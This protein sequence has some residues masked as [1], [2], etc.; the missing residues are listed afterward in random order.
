M[1]Q[2]A[3]IAIEAH[4]G[5]RCQGVVAGATPHLAAAALKTRGLAPLSL[6]ADLSRPKTAGDSNAE[7]GSAARPGTDPS[8][9][10]PRHIRRFG[11]IISRQ[12]LTLF[13][14]QL[15]TLLKAGLPLLRALEVLARPERNPAFKEVLGV[16]ADGVRGGGN[17]S[18]GL[19]QF[20][21]IFDDLHVTMVTAGEAGGSLDVVLERLARFLERT[22][23]IKGRL[24]A[25][26]TY[27]VIIMLVAGLILTGLMIFVVP[28]FQQIFNGVL[29]GQPLPAL[30]RLVIAAGEFVHHHVA[31]AAGL[32]ALLYAAWRFARRSR[33]GTRFI[34]WL[35]LKPPVLG[36]LMLKAAIARFARTFGSLLASGVPILDALLIT[37]AA[38]GNVHVASAL[39]LVH[40]RVK[41]GVAVTQ[42]L[43]CAAIFPSLVTSMIQVGEETGALPEMLGRIADTYDE[44]VDNAVAAL[45]TI[46][47]PV[48]IVLMALVV[49]L[50]VIALFLPIVGIVQHL[51]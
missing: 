3:F 35:L 16:L 8:H 31:A 25:A 45:T 47:E 48:M 37:R 20:P 49:G 6:V 28:R 19:Q 41:E 1:P 30:T 2:F 15:A 39:L 23:R 11:R 29:K 14:R 46:I 40:D 7:A 17:L 51:Q 44:E 24:K 18:A 43:E 10:A 22:E 33:Q 36:D 50:I 42:A 5:R 38:S 13:T 4:T 32:L 26:M 21:R 9:A 34:D 12:G 27:P